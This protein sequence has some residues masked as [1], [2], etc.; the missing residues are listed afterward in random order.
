MANNEVGK[1]YHRPWGAYET[2]RIEENYQVKIL[3]INPG[4]RLSLQKHARRAEHWVVVAGTPTL[5][6]NDTT[7]VYE[8]NESIYIPQQAVHRIENFSD[9]TAKIIEV[10]VGDYLGEDDIVRFEDIYGRT[11]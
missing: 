8:V 3:T 6:V 4:G 5:T 2:L 9:K 11:K 10:Q 7:R 1:I